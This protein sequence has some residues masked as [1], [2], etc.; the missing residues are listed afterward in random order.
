MLAVHIRVDGNMN[1]F[2]AVEAL[3]YCL[4]NETDIW[5]ENHY[6]FIVSNLWPKKFQSMYLYIYIYI[7]YIYIY[8]HRCTCVQILK[9]AMTCLTNMCIIST[10]IGMICLWWSFQR[11][12]T[13]I[14]M[15]YCFSDRNIG[16]PLSTKSHAFRKFS[17][18]HRQKGV[19]IGNFAGLRLTWN[20]M[21][22]RFAYI[23]ILYIYI[24]IDQLPHAWMACFPRHNRC[25][26]VGWLF[27]FLNPAYR[28][29][30]LIGVRIDVFIFSLG[31]LSTAASRVLP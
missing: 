18:A 20:I 25:L 27:W 10:W 6:I 15:F 21:V 13:V 1:C 2:K 17:S 31:A 22:T 7:I 24:Y 9:H 3:T 5:F 8:I 30:V 12:S 14:H 29:W 16:E 19:S 11:N 28:I 4:N 23:C 26:Y